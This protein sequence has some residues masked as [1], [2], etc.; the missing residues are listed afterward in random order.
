MAD[1]EH[2][3]ARL[4][5]R[6]LSIIGHLLM[7]IL[8]A[9]SIAPQTAFSKQRSIV[10]V[11][12]AGPSTQAVALFMNLLSKKNIAKDYAFRVPRR[13]I[14]H[15]GGLQVASK[16]IIGRTGRPLNA[17]E[18]SQG[19]EEIFLSKMQ[20]A[21]AIGQ[22]TG[23]H[24]LSIKQ[25]C[26][27]F[28]GKIRNWKELGGSNHDIVI[29][30]REKTEALFSALKEELACMNRTVGTKYIYKKDHAI[31]NVLA[32][33]EHGNYS[34]GFGAKANFSAHFLVN[35]PGFEAGVSSGLVYKS[36]NRD[37]PVVIAA[38]ELAKS[39]EWIET[40]AKY[41]LLPPGN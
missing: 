5:K 4:L 33:S 7:A 11:A 25:V 22:K 17:K 18:K 24:K 37:Q 9:V 30:G 1:F 15:A 3:F 19:F 23:V 40:L 2:P 27:I 16:Y 32:N 31:I 6:A 21:F 14:K 20:I 10:V 34:I 26:D 36:S 8:M 28:T 35:V 13:S 12:G 38:K 29:I 39:Q 41:K